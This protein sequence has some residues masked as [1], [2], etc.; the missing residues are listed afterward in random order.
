MASGFSSATNLAAAMA[1]SF[2]ILFVSARTSSL[3]P[4]QSPAPSP[5]PARVD[6]TTVVLLTC[7]GLIVI[8]VVAM[9][10]MSICKPRRS[11][12]GGYDGTVLKVQVVLSAR[13]GD[14]GRVLR[15]IF[16]N[17]NRPE[18]ITESKKT[19]LRETINALLEHQNS[20]IYGSTSVKGKP[21]DGICSSFAIGP[22]EGMVRKEMR[23]LRIEREC[24]YN[25]RL[26][27][28]LPPKQDKD[29]TVVMIMVLAAGEHKL[30]AV[31]SSVDVKEALNYLENKFLIIQDVEVMWAYQDPL[32]IVELLDSYPNLYSILA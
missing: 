23:K 8:M 21:S 11:T 24:L 13:A 16:A 19:V 15:D 27:P 22:L 1:L 30:P 14:I 18:P 17:T 5:L 9:A 7:A 32:R 4:P 3:D 25:Y 2:F 28:K 26:V 12:G 6:S 31:S 29:Y 20:F 10:C